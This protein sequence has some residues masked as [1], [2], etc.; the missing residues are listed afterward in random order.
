MA[1]RNITSSKYVG[2]AL[3]FYF[4]GLSLMRTAVERLFSCFIKRNHVSIWSW[5]QKF[6]PQNILSKKINALEFI[7]DETQIK[8]GSELI[9]LWVDIEP[10]DRDSVNIYIK[11]KEYVCGRVLSV[12]IGSIMESIQFLQTEAHGIHHKH[13]SF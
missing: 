12:D 1:N 10:K 9:W 8:A 11:R 13:V 2:Y 3:Y 5:I 6:K 7:I 4:S